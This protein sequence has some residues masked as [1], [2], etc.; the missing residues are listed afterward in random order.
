[1]LQKLSKYEV[2]VLTLLKLVILLPLRF[3]V[4]SNYGEFKWSKNVVFDNSRGSE[5]G[6]DK[7]LKF[8][9]NQNSETL[10][11]PKTTF[12]VHLNSPKFDFT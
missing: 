5:L 12:L 6:T 3:Y 1:M 7:M 11:L 10:K 4:K 2:K 9:K 8:T